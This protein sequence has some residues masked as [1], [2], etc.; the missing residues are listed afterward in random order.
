M[1]ALLVSVP[2]RSL[3]PARLPRKW[4]PALVL[5][6]ALAAAGCS[7][8]PKPQERVTGDGGSKLLRLSSKQVTVDLDDEQRAALATM[9][10]KRF[11]TPDIPA[12]LASCAS[13]L[14]GM[15]FQPVT[16]D[17]QVMIVE[18]EQD[19]VVGTRW[20]EAIRAI[21]KAKGI[22][23]SG[24]PDHQSIKALVTVRPEQTGILVRARFTLTVW[25]TNG[26]SR[27]ETIIDRG[28]YDEFFTA[29]TA[30]TTPTPG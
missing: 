5:S 12:V 1:S 30:A 16:T 6:V 2:P 18:G 21:L 20:R 24:R 7:H 15:D 28:L 29:V 4:G 11:A 25:D 26:D 9:Q 23:L 14:R 10:D 22:P 27:T 3:G 13:A 17:Q 19:K 8:D